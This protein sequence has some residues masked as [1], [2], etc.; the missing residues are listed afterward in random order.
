MNCS[1]TSNGIAIR[2]FGNVTNCYGKGGFDGI[3][4]WAEGTATS[5]RGD[6]YAVGGTALRAAIAVS[7]TRAQGIIDSPSKHL[8]TP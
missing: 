7:C 4:I 5:C 1:A 8:G 6:H 3:G 2:A